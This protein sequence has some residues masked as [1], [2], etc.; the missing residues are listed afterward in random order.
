MCGYLL[1]TLKIKY[2]KV[3]LKVNVPYCVCPWHQKQMLVASQLNLPAYNYYNLWIFTCYRWQSGKSF[4]HISVYIWLLEVIWYLK[5][6]IW[7]IKQI[8]L[9]SNF[10]LNQMSNLQTNYYI[11]NPYLILKIHLFN[12]VFKPSIATV[13]AANTYFNLPILTFSSIESL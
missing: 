7:Y 3:V 1:K 12:D 2:M 11:Q 13:V 8:F 5:V 6:A 9:N 4:W 10:C